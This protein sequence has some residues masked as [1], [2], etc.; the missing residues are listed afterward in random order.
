MQTTLHTKTTN[1]QNSIPQAPSENIKNKM[2]SLWQEKNMTI[3]NKHQ[4]NDRIDLSPQ[5]KNKI[6]QFINELKS[7]EDKKIFFSH[8]FKTM[9]KLG[10]KEKQKFIAGVSQ[11][12]QSSSD[13]EFVSLNK[14]FNSSLSHYMAISLASIPLS[15]QLRHNMTSISLEGDND[16]DEIII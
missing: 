5:E 14:K 2:S 16:E 1:V 8:V 13:P 10:R 4:D 6:D 12:L 11:T 15:N 3:K 7:K 9:I